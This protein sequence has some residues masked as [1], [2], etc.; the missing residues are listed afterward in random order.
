MFRV[1]EKPPHKW[2]KSMI[3]MI[4]L[5]K[6]RADISMP[7]F[8]DYYENRHVPLIMKHLGRYFSSYQRS[9]LSYAH[10]LSYVGGFGGDGPAIT[11]GFDVLTEISFGS[12][13]ELDAMF[14]T[15]ASITIATE[16]ADDEARFLDRAK[17]QIVISEEHCVTHIDANTAK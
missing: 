6:R 13:A 15:L 11:T 4:A 9:Y 17:N 2:N 1:A 7:Q 16:I 12:V 5:L 10:P 14:K 3:K 8:I